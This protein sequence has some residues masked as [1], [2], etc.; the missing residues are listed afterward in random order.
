MKINIKSKEAWEAIKLAQGKARVHCFYFIEWDG[1]GSVAEKALK[2]INLPLTHR[3]GAI[4][5]IRSGGKIPMAYKWRRV[6]SSVTLQRGKDSW[7]LIACHTG[8][9]NDRKAGRT[10]VKLKQKQADYLVN[11]LKSNFGIQS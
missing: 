4:V 9:T 2:S 7:F 5:H 6:V 8:E 11:K 3:Q 10:F 1:M